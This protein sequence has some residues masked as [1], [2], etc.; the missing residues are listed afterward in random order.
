MLLPAVRTNTLQEIINSL[1]VKSFRDRDRRDGSVVETEGAVALFAVEVDVDIVVIIVMMTAA[2]FVA[3]AVA[4][5][6]KDVHEVS[7][8]EGLQGPEDVGF[9][10]GFE[11]GFQFRHGHRTAGRGEGAGDD[12]T[13]RRG[14]HAMAFHQFQQ[15]YLFHTN[16]KIRD[17]GEI[18]NPYL[19]GCRVRA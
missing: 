18:R 7:L 15:V 17:C 6:V 13:V 4:G 19:S 2:E 14:L 5:V 1:Y 12:D 3:D 9:V 10:D 8:A 16:A 11:D